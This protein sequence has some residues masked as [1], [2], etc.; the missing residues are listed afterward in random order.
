[1][2]YE[3]EPFG[4][5]VVLVEPGVIRTNFV[6]G[7]VAAKKSQDPNS[8]YSQIIQKMA[9]SFEPMLE[10]GSSAD[11]VAKV[12]LNAV[13]SENPSPKYLAG[14]DIETLMEA[15]RSMSDE[16]FSKMMTQNFMK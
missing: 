3:L 11:V 7:L 14:K 4:I 10:N 8:P 6:N 16:E 13:T 1:M 9:A 2:A 12:V 15:K 5:R